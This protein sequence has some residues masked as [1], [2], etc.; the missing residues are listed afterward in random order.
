MYNLNLSYDLGS[1]VQV[2]ESA[3]KTER[4]RKS[5]R[6]CR[7]SES[8]SFGRRSGSMFVG[9]IDVGDMLQMSPTGP[10]GHVKGT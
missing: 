4:L 3:P 1:S 9:D 2:P 5:A 7:F 6:S 8:F 10:F